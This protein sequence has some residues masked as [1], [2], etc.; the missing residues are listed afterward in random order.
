MA[1]AVKL[2]G[3]MRFLFD[4]RG[5]LADEYA[6]AGHWKRGGV[7]YRLAKRM[8]RVFFRRADA[9]VMLTCAI[10]AQL[11]VTERALF[12]RAADID[13][14]PCC[15]EM[16]RF[17]S[18]P[19]QWRATR[20]KRGWENKRV[21]IYVGKLG[22]WY[23]VEEMARFFAEARQEDGRFFFQVLT[24]SD[25]STM[26]QALEAARVPR[27]AYDVDFVPPGEIP[28]ILGAADAGISFRT[29]GSG[30]R[31][32]SPTKVTEYLAAGLPV[33]S[34]RGIGDWDD[35]FGK[36]NLGVT[37]AQL[38]RDEYRQAARRLI[39]LI[40][41]PITAVACRAFAERERSVE[42]VAGPRY[43]S[44]YNRLLG[45]AATEASRR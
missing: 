20:R 18:D 23:L 36:Q 10:K 14:I 11:L 13:V 34:T 7:K 26:K 21:L 29:V 15:V 27:E 3:G 6:D 32:A 33:V 42:M 37:V 45:G 8:E 41:D 2:L 39:D 38:H 16:D 4:L 30:A 31:S 9:L 1:L 12:G 25:P 24:Q 19:E 43:L 22:S 44:V 40:D 17:R 35:I 28:Q 5:L